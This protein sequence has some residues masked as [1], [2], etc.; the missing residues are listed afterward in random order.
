VE[1]RQARVHPVVDVAVVVVAFL[2]AV[3]GA[4]LPRRQPDTEFPHV[5]VAERV[6]LEDRRAVLEDDEGAG[7]A[8]GAFEGHLSLS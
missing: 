4:V 8:A 5:R 2:V 3:L 1:K 6:A 7:V